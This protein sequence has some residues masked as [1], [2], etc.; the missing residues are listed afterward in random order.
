MGG[1]LPPAFAANGICGVRITVAHTVMAIN[2]RHEGD[3]PEKRKT[4]MTFLMAAVA[5]FLH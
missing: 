5:R 4:Y 2:A 1:R 3:C